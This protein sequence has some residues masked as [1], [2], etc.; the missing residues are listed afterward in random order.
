MIESGEGLGGCVPS[1]KLVT[2]WV[3]QQSGSGVG[4][5]VCGLGG[6]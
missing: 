4:G 3:A 1:L 5:L 2:V 6:V